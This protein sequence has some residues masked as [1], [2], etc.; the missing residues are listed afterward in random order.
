MLALQVHNNDMK[1]KSLSHLSLHR[2]DPCVWLVLSKGLPIAVIT[3]VLCLLFP[4]IICCFVFNDALLL[5]FLFTAL[6]FCPYRWHGAVLPDDG[7]LLLSLAAAC[8]CCPYRGLAIVLSLDGGGTA[9]YTE[10]EQVGRV[11]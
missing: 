9:G 3:V 2:T 7:L 10:A 1:H 4:L 5:L 11:R 6:H 8:H